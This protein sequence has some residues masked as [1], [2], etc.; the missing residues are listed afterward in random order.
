MARAIVDPRKMRDFDSRIDKS[1]QGTDREN[2]H[3]L[4]RR[5]KHCFAGSEYDLGKTNLVEHVIDTG[6]ALPI[7]Q[8][9][10]RSAFKERALIQ[11][12]VNDMLD[13]GVIEP[14]QG[15]WASPVVLV[16]KKN[17]KWRFC[18]DYRR[19]N[20]VTKKDVY[21]LPR[22]D[23]ALSRL[24]GATI[25]SSL[26]LQAGYWQVPIRPEDREKT[27]FITPDGLYQFKVMG[28][29][30]ASA[31]NTF[32]RLMDMVLAGVKWSVCMAYMD[33]MI[34]YA[35]GHQQHL[36]RLEI[37]LQ[38]VEQSKMKL[39]LDK[40]WFGFRKLKIL[41]HVVSA[42]GVGPDPEKIKAVQEFPPPPSTGSDAKKITHVQSFVGLC[43]YYRNFIRDFA[44]RAKPLTEL[45]KKKNPF[46]WGQEEQE[47]FEDLKKALAEAATL[48]H[49]D[50]DL[51][52]EIHQDACA[53]GIG[54]ALVQRRG[55]QQVPIAFAS[56]LMTPAEKNYHIT[57][58]ECLA[59]VWALK[60]FRPLIYGG[61]I[62]VVTDHHALCWLTTKREL[63]GR[64]ARWALLTQEFQLSIVHKSGR[65]HLDA[66][67]LSRCPVDPAEELID[68][69]AL[70]TISLSDGD[71]ESATSQLQ[72]A[73]RE[74]PEWR[75]IIEYLEK[76]EHGKKK[77]YELRDG[78]LYLRMVEGSKCYSRLCIPPGKFRQD[79]MEA[80]HDDLLSGHLGTTRTLTKLRHRYH[81]RRMAQHVQ[82]YVQ[83]CQLCQTRKSPKLKPAGMMQYIETELPFERIGMDILGPFPVSESGNTN[84]IVAVD[85]LTKWCETK[86]VPSATAEAVAHFFTHQIVLK[87]GAPRALITDQGKCFTARMFKAILQ[88]LKM[89]HRTAAAYHAQSVGQ[90][91]RWYKSHISYDVINVCKR[92]AEQLG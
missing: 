64:L 23:D 46:R 25:F 88:Q 51:P 63:S 50:P 62:L 56:R 60:K 82:K 36:E 7:S 21:P 80:I 92:Q 76:N 2:L 22:I 61:Q 41:G 11:E 67:A 74:V 48:A 81:W 91:E 57:E 69:E 42:E 16:M 5:Y 10:R 73:Q 78:L 49:L 59:L 79:V 39:N 55:D 84:I 71:S 8:P 44:V 70:F 86:A 14:A 17:G 3:A 33:D 18:V 53:Y 77:N 26:D 83:S 29:G 43:S 31:P 66:D 35:N 40:C 58:Q 38:R 20:A 34:P 24:Q 27:A 9:P 85:Y 12:Q 6:D 54:A 75:K 72:E 1:V 13:K 47:S 30:L 28:F 15:P 68:D 4:L 87:H 90:V 65:L 19:L 45:T 52:M 89:E 32:Q 37:V